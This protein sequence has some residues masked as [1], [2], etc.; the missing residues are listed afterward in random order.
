MAITIMYMILTGL[1]RQTIKLDIIT[2]LVKAE[3]L[4][5]V[6]ELQIMIQWQMKVLLIQ[7][8]TLLDRLME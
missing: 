3:E 5:I 6:T 7:E 1:V 2:Q 4:N 8:I